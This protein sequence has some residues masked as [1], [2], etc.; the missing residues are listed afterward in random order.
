MEEVDFSTKRYC[1]YTW[2]ELQLK[3]LRVEISAYDDAKTSKSKTHILI[4]PR[5]VN[6]VI[7]FEDIT[8]V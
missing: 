1:T 2:A 7:K 4:F 3:D 5:I 8:R 6:I